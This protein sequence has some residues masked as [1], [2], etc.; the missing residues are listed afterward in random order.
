MKRFI[1]IILLIFFVIGLSACKD[2][3]DPNVDENP[4]PIEDVKDNEPGI[5]II[6]VSVE[7]DR[8]GRGINITSGLCNEIK[9]GY[10]DTFYKG[11]KY[12]DPNEEVKIL[13]YYG[14]YNGCV[15]LRLSGPSGYFPIMT[16]EV[17]AD[18]EFLYGNNNPIIV[19]TNYSFYNLTEAYESGKL[20]KTHI[21]EISKIHNGE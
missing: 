3:S 4:T 7:Y 19:Y 6:D 20:L 17:V 16:N 14:V 2:T 8:R 11:H 13:D 15:V 18:I 5:I 1:M 12:D 9:K 10:L 21:Q